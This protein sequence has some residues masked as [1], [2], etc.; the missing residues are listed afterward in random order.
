MKQVEDASVDEIHNTCGD[1]VKLQSQVGH[2]FRLSTGYR[3]RPRLQGVALRTDCDI[4]Y[5]CS[6]RYERC[7]FDNRL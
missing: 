3:S 5:I 6:S 2:D 4:S 1:W 7:V